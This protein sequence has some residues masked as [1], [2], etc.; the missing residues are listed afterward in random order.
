MQTQHL[1][2][3]AAQEHR[4]QSSFKAKEL[5]RKTLNMQALCCFG[6]IHTQKALLSN[7]HILSLNTGHERQNKD[8]ERSLLLASACRTSKPYSNTNVCVYKV[9]TISVL[10]LTFF[11]K[12]NNK[13][14]GWKMNESNCQIWRPCLLLP[15]TTWLGH[16]EVCCHNS[17]KD[18][19]KGECNI[20]QG[21][22]TELSSAWGLWG[23]GIASGSQV[24]RNLP[25]AILPPTQHTLSQNDGFLLVGHRFVVQKI[26]KPLLVF[27]HLIA[28]F[29]ASFTLWAQKWVL[30]GLQD[31]LSHSCPHSTQKVGW[32]WQGRY[33]NNTTPVFKAAVLTA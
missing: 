24:P 18:G 16:T 20:D 27:Q 4:C 21:P 13:L 1:W 10:F 11:K 19:E 32:T 15:P 3:K 9:F 17:G 30:G 6:A 12:E 23:I 26:I 29:F 5:K 2:W 8:V 14:S 7:Q 31:V 25:R 22:P 28:T 33:S